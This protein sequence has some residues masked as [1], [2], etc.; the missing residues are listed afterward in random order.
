MDAW[1][2]RWVR[3]ERVDALVNV[4]M[5]S[6][7]GSLRNGR[8]DERQIHRQMDGWEPYRTACTWSHDT[9]RSKPLDRWE[10]Y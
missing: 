3:E 6:C 7:M 8:M 2:T 4:C 1:G 5:H 10:D 9:C